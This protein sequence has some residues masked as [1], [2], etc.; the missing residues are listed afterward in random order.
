MNQAIV[1]SV[2]EGGVNLYNDVLTV[3]RLLN[4]VRA[5]W[6]GP[7]IKLVED[8]KVGN[9]TKGAI[10]AFQ[11]L[12]LNTVFAPDGRVDANGATWRRLTL[13]ASSPDKPGGV[14]RVSVE[15]IPHER[16]PESMLCWAAAGTMLVNARDKTNKGID[17][18]LTDASARNPG[19]DY[20]TLYVNKQEL[21]PYSIADYVKALGLKVAQAVNFTVPTWMSIMRRKGAL[22]VCGLMPMLHIRVVTEIIS[23]GT[24]FGTKILVHDP[25][26]AQ[27]Y[28]ESFLS[29]VQ[30]YEAAAHGPSAG[31]HQVW[32]R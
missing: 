25:M 3:Q 21:Q 22:G 20:M 13:I 26:E 30:K 16:Q 1:Q 11:V 19:I 27:P 32:H 24:A 18:V 12:Q 6:G 31:Y 15:P 28:W 29:F 17:V 23:D 7:A 2:G 5:E 10:R 9:H 8:G 14:T 4:K